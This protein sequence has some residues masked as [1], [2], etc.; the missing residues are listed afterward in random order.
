MFVVEALEL[1][2][3]RRYSR[4]LIVIAYVNTSRN[5]RE[6]CCL[7][8]FETKRNFVSQTFIKKS[9]LFENEMISQ[10]MQIVD[11]RIIFFYD[12]YRLNIELIDHVDTRQHESIEFQVV[13]MREYEMI[14]EFF[15]LNNID[16]DI[17]WRE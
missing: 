7:V 5:I 13:N 17:N 15:W 9:E 14:L 2:T 16:L 6:V 3:K 4:A 12:T 1:K 11:D 8:D 10:R